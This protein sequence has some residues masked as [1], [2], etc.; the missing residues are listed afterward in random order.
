[1][2]IRGGRTGAQEDK[3]T[4]EDKRGGRSADPKKEKRETKECVNTGIEAEVGSVAAQTRETDEMNC[5]E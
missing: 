3:R 1:M 2:K 4:Q 5:P